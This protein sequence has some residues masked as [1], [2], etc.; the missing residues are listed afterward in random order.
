M[1]RNLYEKPGWYMN[2]S[3]FPIQF[4]IHNCDIPIGPAHFHRTM[5]E[6]FFIIQGKVK[7][8][9]QG[10]HISLEK[11]D[12]LVINPGEV[13]E[14]VSRSSDAEYVLLLPAPVPNDKVEVDNTKYG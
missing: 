2:D 12:L 5:H 4:G 7:L 11:G 8:S 1:Y 14:M 13:H 9:V 3:N 10:R 6:Y